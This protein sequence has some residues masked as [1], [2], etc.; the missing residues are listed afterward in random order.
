M[1]SQPTSQ[2]REVLESLGRAPN[3]TMSEQDVA[4]LLDLHLLRVQAC[5][6]TDELADL[7]DVRDGARAALATAARLAPDSMVVKSHA[8]QLDQSLPPLER[9]VARMEQSGK[10][11]PPPPMPGQKGTVPPPPPMPGPKGATAR[12]PPGAPAA[13]RAAQRPPRRGSPEQG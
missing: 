1:S 4:A 6:H 3:A 2:I 12:P 13:R 11:P 8:Q 9:L 5:Q 10:V 7:T